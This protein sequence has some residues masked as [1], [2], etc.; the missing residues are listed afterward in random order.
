MA[1]R[2]SILDEANSL[3]PPLTQAR[4]F[5]KNL[6]D[7]DRAEWLELL[8]RGDLYPASAVIALF[9]KRGVH[10]DRHM[11]HKLRSEQAGYVPSR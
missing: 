9:A 2:P 5:I 3:I 7:A 8:R 6:P 4:Q 10:I 1:D 11:C